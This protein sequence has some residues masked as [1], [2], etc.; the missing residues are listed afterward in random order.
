MISL[1]SR[2]FAGKHFQQLLLAIEV[3]ASDSCQ[4]GGELLDDLARDALLQGVPIL[5]V[6][7]HWGLYWG[8][9]Y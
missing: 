4:F 3:V 1:Y 2:L 5:L 7:I 6:I 9:P 8:P